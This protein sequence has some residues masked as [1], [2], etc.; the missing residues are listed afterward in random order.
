LAVVISVFLGI[1]S[2]RRWK[3][4]AREIA[5]RKQAE[6]ELQKAKEAAEA[7]NQAKS[8]FVA[9]MSHEIRTP[10]NGV[11]GMTRLLLDTNLT[12]EQRYYTETVRDSGDTLLTIIDDILDFSKIEAGKLR[13]ETIDFDLWMEVEAVAGLLAERAHSKGLELVSFVDDNVPRAV[14]GDPGRL[15]QIL[16]NLLGNAIK[17]TEEGEIVLRADLTEERDTTVLMRFEVTD[18]GI[19]LTPEQQERLFRAFSQADTSTTRDYGGTGLGLTISKQLVGMMGGE[20]GVESERGKGS[21]FWFTMWLEKQPAGAQ[22]GPSSR[23]DLRD[24]RILIADDNHT[25]RA[26]LHQQ[27]ISWGM[28]NGSVENGPRALEL[29]RAAADRGE[30]YD[31]AILDEQMPGMDGLELARQIKAEPAIAS[32]RLVLLT[33]LEQHREGEELHQAGIAASL[34]KPVRQSELFD[35]LATVM[36]SVTEEIP[37][38]SRTVVTSDAE[39]GYGE[40]EAKPSTRVLLAEDNAVNQE[41]AVQI[42][43]KLGYRVDVVRNGVEALEALSH[44]PY[45]AVLM[46]CQMPMMDG[47]EAT[48]MIR[49]HEGE[50]HHTPIIAMTAHA[51]QGE[52][53]KCLAVGMDDYISKPV[54][55]EE[56]DASLKRWVSRATPTTESLASEASSAEAMGGAIDHSVLAGLRNLQQEGKPDVLKRLI[57]VFISDTQSKL[58][59]LREAAEQGEAQT[60]ER[61]AHTLKGSSA[62]LGAKEMAATC[63]ELETFTRSGNLSKISDLL[64]RLEVEFE[65]AREALTAELT[66]G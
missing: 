64:A 47:Y 42:L 17:F 26:I 50:V 14:R 27:I 16:T 36:G 22:V 29:L 35:C 49:R 46:D 37:T 51:L 48:A 54:K 9:N 61:V 21:T 40:A 33:S 19:G 63:T 2:R 13:L 59:A 5:K 53:E 60:L 32:V 45:D 65:R 31:L 8:E 1:F 15:R 6:E 23:T 24:V 25:N 18:T 44:I 12:R 34:T 58:V 41:V 52:R 11:I 7:A 4:A 3:E 38:P 10:M 62:S 56:L 57:G 66:K 39:H 28:R 30:P 20:I 55:P 43:E